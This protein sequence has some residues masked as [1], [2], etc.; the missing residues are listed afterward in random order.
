MLQ[1]I[2]E[3]KSIT[4]TLLLIR[5]TKYLLKPKLGTSPGCPIFNTVLLILTNVIRHEKLKV[6]NKGKYIKL[7]IE[8]E[9]VV[10]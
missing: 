10:C 4:G 6:N 1:T 5:N 2:I 9:T 8:D 3:E 7:F